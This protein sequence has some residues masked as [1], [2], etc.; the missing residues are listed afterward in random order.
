[1]SPLQGSTASRPIWVLD[2]DFS[3]CKIRCDC[4]SFVIM[5]SFASIDLTGKSLHWSEKL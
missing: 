1:M 2:Y 3:S 4:E 5:N